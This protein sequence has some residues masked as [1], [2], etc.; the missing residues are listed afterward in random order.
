MRAPRRLQSSDDAA[1]SRYQPALVATLVLMTRRRAPLWLARRYAST[2]P[3]NRSEA[4]RGASW[5]VKARGPW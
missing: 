5:P 1:C 2:A 3:G 4:M